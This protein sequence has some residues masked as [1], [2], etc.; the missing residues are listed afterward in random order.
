MHKCLAVS[1]ILALGPSAFT[2]DKLDVDARVK[3]IAP[4]LDEQTLGVAHVDLTRVDTATL[5]SWVARIGQF[6][7]QSADA[8]KNAVEEW[9]KAFRKAGGKD[10]YAFF[11][12]ADLPQNPPFLI[13]PLEGQADGEALSKLFQKG[14]QNVPP[15]EVA[16]KLGNVLFVGAKAT[17]QR[18]ATL[19]PTPHPEL[20]KAIAAAGDTAAQVLLLPSADARRALQESLPTL[21][22]QFGGVPITTITDGILWGALGVDGPP[23]LAVHLFIQSKDARAAD[24]LQ[25]WITDFWKQVGQEKGVRQALP[26]FNALTKHL[27]P[28]AQ[29]DHLTLN[30]GEKD[31]TAFLTPVV[32]QTRLSASRARSMNNLK[33]IVLALH[34]YHDSKGRFPTAALYSKDGKPLLSWRVAILPYVEHGEL[35]K[36]F[37]LDEPW[38]S[39]HNKK[40]I[41]RMPAVFQARP[42]LP[43]GKTTY[44]GVA[45]KSAMFP[46]DPK[47]LRIQ[48]VTDG[49]S[50]TIFIVEATPDHA[51]IWT[52][53]EDYNYDP[54]KPLAG[55]RGAEGGF[56]AAFVDGSVR[57]ISNTIDPKTLDALFTRNG[58]EVIGNIP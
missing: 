1:L 24:R 30:V 14:T 31:L 12:L 4:Y 44:L 10:V 8:F 40:L 48:D 18:L 47:P 3:A 33:Q 25:A 26:N 21:P 6:P 16:E 45:G 20:A 11:S 23:Q 42:D 22:K 9:V 28:T 34:N 41:A 36:E 35:Y 38:D 27:T 54:A 2:A 13:V 39:E 37:K 15:A 32:R 49:T 58:G 7:T 56:I 46:P 43:A 17:R 5:T 29:G 51:V 50:N 55:L 19:K 57:F 52:K 53:P